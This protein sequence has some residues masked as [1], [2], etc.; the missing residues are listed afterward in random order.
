MSE[1]SIMK[2]NHEKLL[3]TDKIGYYKIKYKCGGHTFLNFNVYLP[4]IR[5]FIDYPQRRFSLFVK[6][7][8]T[9]NQLL[10]L[11][12]YL[13]QQLPDYS[14][15]MSIT[16][17]QFVINLKLNPY[18]IQYHNSNKQ[19]AH[20]SFKSIRKTVDNFNRVILYIR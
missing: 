3:I 12:S 1:V 19:S 9:V 14:R 17:N 2:Y 16:D 6:D 4:N 10:S 11:D 8:Q 7:T 15:F 5:T 13:E 18:L 20:L